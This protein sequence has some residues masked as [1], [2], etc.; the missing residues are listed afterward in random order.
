M[1]NLGSGILSNGSAVGEEATLSNNDTP[2]QKETIPQ[3][4]QSFRDALNLHSW[5]VKFEILED[6]KMKKSLMKIIPQRDR[7]RAKIYIRSSLVGK[8]MNE[9]GPLLLHEMMHLVLDPIME[10]YTMQSEYEISVTRSQEYMTRLIKTLEQ[11]ID[12]LTNTLCKYV[13]M[14]DDTKRELLRD[15]QQDLQALHNGINGD[16]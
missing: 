2:V 8:P 1:S 5:T 3:L 9:F 10:E 6:D 13:L 4:I 15:I 7:G 16:L 14:T 12:H 11:T